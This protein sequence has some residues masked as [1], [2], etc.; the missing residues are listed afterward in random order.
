MEERRGAE[1]RIPKGMKGAL[2]SEPKPLS[3]AEAEEVLTSFAAKSAEHSSP[4][5]LTLHTV[6]AHISMIR[7]GEDKDHE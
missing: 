5:L 7:E 4:A 1:G 3:M 6:T 2:L